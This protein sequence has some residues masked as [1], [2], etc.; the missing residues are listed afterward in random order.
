MGK[1]RRGY[2]VSR[3]RLRGAPMAQAKSW[4]QDLTPDAPCARCGNGAL[5]TRVRVQWSFFDELGVA[6]ATYECPH[7]G[8]GTTYRCWTTAQEI[9]ATVNATT[10]K[11]GIE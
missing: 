3:E 7:C 6:E 1:F 8:Q 9:D 4:A 11:E 2:R 10:L 5:I